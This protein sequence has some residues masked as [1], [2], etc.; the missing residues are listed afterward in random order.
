MTNEPLSSIYA[1]FFEATKVTLPANRRRELCGPFV[2]EPTRA[3]LESSA[4]IMIFGQET[5][6]W[7]YCDEL[8][9]ARDG[10]GRSRQTYVNF[11]FGEKHHITSLWSFYRRIADALG[12]DRRAL[13][14]NNL[15]KFDHHGPGEHA[16][17]QE[18]GPVIWT[19]L[20]EPVLRAQQGISGREIKALGVRFCV[21]LTGPDYDHVVE[22][23]FPGARFEKASDALSVRQFATVDLGPSFPPALRTY[24]PEGLRWQRLTTPVLEQVVSAL[25]GQAV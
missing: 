1:D 23:S 2:L 21:F 15:V 17:S 9:D 14:W 11:D 8:L 12:V 19:D 22:R 18:C 13:L 24:H 10:I 16:G 4:R 7:E 25:S 6:G 20:H 3:F 5:K